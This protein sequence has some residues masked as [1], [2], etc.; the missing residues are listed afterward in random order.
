MKVET[1]FELLSVSSGWVLTLIPTS[2]CALILGQQKIKKI[3][4]AVKG[5][6]CM[7][8]LSMDFK[9]VSTHESFDGIRHEQ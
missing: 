1:Q 8:F 7:Y 5:S 9:E 3:N 2:A 6:S 4:F